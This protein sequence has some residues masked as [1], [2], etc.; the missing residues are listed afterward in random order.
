MGGWDPGCEVSDGIASVTTK[1][2]DTVAQICGTSPA[3]VPFTEEELKSKVSEDG[4]VSWM[5]VDEKEAADFHLNILIIGSFDSEDLFTKNSLSDSEESVDSFTE[6]SSSWQV[7]CVVG[8][9]PLKGDFSGGNVK[10]DRKKDL[11]FVHGDEENMQGI[12]RRPDTWSKCY[13]EGCSVSGY[14]GA[15]LVH[16]QCWKLLHAV[17]K[18]HFRNLITPKIFFKGAS[19]LYK[20]KESEEAK[21]K[22]KWPHKKLAYDGCGQYVNPLEGLDERYIDEVLEAVKTTEKTGKIDTKLRDDLWEKIGAWLWHPI[23]R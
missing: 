4:K 1:R 10:R 3:L 23:D 2:S 12:S 20:D 13:L 15:F 5:P 8:Y 11:W 18:S 16:T 21:S 6:G 19:K 7:C 17:C 9:D 22:S 14:N